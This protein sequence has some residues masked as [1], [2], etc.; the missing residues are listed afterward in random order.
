PAAT[1]GSSSRQ[2][3]DL[4]IEWLKAHKDAPFFLWSHFY[5][6]HFR[7]EPHPDLPE[8]NFGTDEQA[9][10]DGE[11]RYADHHIGRVLDTLRELGLWDKTIVIVTSDHGD[12]FGEHGI[13]QSKRHGYHL[14][15]TETKVPVLMHVPGLAPRVVMTPIGHVDLIPT[16]LNLLRRS[17]GDEPQLAGE[18]LLAAMLG[19]DS[20]ADA[21][22]IYQEVWYEG[23]TSKQALVTKGAHLIRNLVPE[24][25]TELYDFSNDIA[26]EHDLAGSGLPLETQLSGRLA[27]ITDEIAIPRD[28]AT[29]LKDA[30]VPKTPQQPLGDTLGDY[31]HVVGVDVDHP[32]VTSTDTA[33]VTVHFRI[34]RAIPEGW[35][36]FTHV[37]AP[38]GRTTNLDHAPLENLMPLQTLGPG[39]YLRDPISIALPADWPPGPSHVEL[40][41]YRRGQRARAVGKHSVGD[42]VTVATIQVTR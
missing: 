23:P 28:F 15:R 36:L 24:D 41:L 6:T 39:T 7:F 33:V 26:E 40:G 20:R 25:T 42:A 16:L 8:T 30:R 14:Y 2:L 4:D 32:T 19:D 21:R 17:V 34:D 11:I 22:S 27:A 5:D 35:L 10:Y 31:A 13:P 37:V 9:L 12:G 3:A 18:S 29:R 38:N 1:S